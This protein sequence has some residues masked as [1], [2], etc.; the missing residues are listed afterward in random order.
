MNR[1][2]KNCKGITL[3]EVIVSVVLVIIVLVSLIAAVIQGSVLSRRMD[4]IYTAS[5][6]AQR[7]IDL[8]KRFNFDQLS[9]AAETDIR[10]DADGTVNPSGN[11]VRTTEIDTEFDDNPY[12]AK[13]K[14]SVKKIKV[15]IDGSISSTETL[16][17][18]VIMETLFADI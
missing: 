13:I 6:L 4:M 2:L 18:P 17:Q 14:V 8:L 15:N 11:Y 12:L 3:V 1:L 9:A 10:M 16:G 7:R 5:S